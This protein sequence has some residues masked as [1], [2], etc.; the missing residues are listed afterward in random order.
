MNVLNGNIT[1]T[2]DETK[3]ENWSGVP[4]NGKEIVGEAKGET[5]DM[6]IIFTGAGKI[7]IQVETFKAG[8]IDE[9]IRTLRIELIIK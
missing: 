5:A 3:Q 1:W 7:E 9:Y 8:V 6:P 2:T 4:V